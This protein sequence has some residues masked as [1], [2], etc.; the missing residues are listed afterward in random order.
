M[1]SFI[2]KLILILFVCYLDLR[3]AAVLSQIYVILPLTFLTY[4]LYLYKSN[5]N[6][7]PFESFFTGLFIDLITNTYLGHNAILFCFASY[8]VNTYV[9]TFKLFSYLQICI[10]F[11]LSSSAF[12]GFSQLIVN[13]Y[14]FS[15]LTLLISTIF[16]IVFCLLI[17][18]IS[19][20]FPGLFGRRI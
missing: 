14:N 3:L 4:L 1:T 5:N 19:V 2:K 18:I 9:N 13:L 6:I 15:Y 12:V 7:G 8:A 17:A 20:Y 10:F 16:N 11:G